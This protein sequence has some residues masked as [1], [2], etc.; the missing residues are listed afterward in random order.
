MKQENIDK[1]IVKLFENRLSEKEA[2]QLYD[3]LQDNANADYFDRFV[4][5][6]HLINTEEDFDY[7]GSLR[8]I[9]RQIEGNKRK[10]HR[11][12]LLK[13]AAILVVIAGIAYFLIQ[14]KETSSDKESQ[15]EKIV[16]NNIETGSNKAILTLGN[17]NDISLDSTK[18]YQNNN[19]KSQGKRLVYNKIEDKEEKK[20]DYNYLTVPRGGQYAIELSDGTQVWLNS[21]SKLKYPTEFVEGKTRK[22]KLVYGEAYFKVGSGGKDE[23]NRFIVDVHDMAVEDL[24]TEFNVKAYQDEDKT[25]TTLAKGKVAVKKDN[26]QTKTKLKPRQQAILGEDANEFEVKTLKSLNELL[27]RKGVF[28]FKHKPLNDIMNVLSRWYDMEVVFE[29]PELKEVEF[30]GAL[31]K[32]QPIEEIMKIMHETNNINFTIEDKTLTIK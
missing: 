28:N 21:E 3:W 23:D 26:E 24:G 10:R 31:A 4:E 30:T 7:R 14:T 17:G 5:L 19:V 25:Y 13:Y 8:K 2:E 20:V 6:N 9:R 16:H 12:G 32:K 1:L 11:A 22:V 18:T 15:S 27:W 29:S